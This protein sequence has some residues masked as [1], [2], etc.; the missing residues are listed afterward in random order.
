MGNFSSKSRFYVKESLRN[1]DEFLQ[2][3]ENTLDKQKIDQYGLHEF[4]KLGKKH[5]KLTEK[6]DISHLN[7]SF[8]YKYISEIREYLEWGDTRS[9]E[10]YT[11]DTPGQDET[12][13]ESLSKVAKFLMGKLRISRNMADKI[14]QR[15]AEKGIDLLKVQQKWSIL[16]PS[17]M[18]LVAEYDPQER[19]N[20]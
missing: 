6:L 8:I 16:G 14:I 17:L 1:I 9:L 3:R 19:K 12:V 10:K 20:G 7:N 15:A 11:E 2:I 4:E 18:S 13:Q 5:Y